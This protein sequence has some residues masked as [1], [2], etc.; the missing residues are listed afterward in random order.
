[1]FIVN[2]A[3]GRGRC[4]HRWRAFLPQLAGA[5]FAF[6]VHATTRPGEASEVARQAQRAGF[7]RIVA[8]GGDGTLHEVVNGVAVGQGVVGVLPFGTGN[9]VARSLGLPRRADA[10]FEMLADNRTVSLD[11]ALVNGRRCLMA[12]GVG[13]DGDVVARIRQHPGIQRLGKFGYA[14]GAC[15]ALFAFRPQPAR[16]TVDDTSLFVPRAWMITIANCPYYAGG[17][18]I[19]PDARWHDGLLDVCVVADLD[20]GRF[21]RLFPLVFSGRHVRHHPYVTVLRGQR[22]CVQAAAAWPGHT[23]GESLVADGLRAEVMQGGVRLLAAVPDLVPRATK[24]RADEERADEER[25]DEK[26]ADK[27]MQGGGVP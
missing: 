11:L 25:I 3:A 18:R 6:E 22:V 8:V 13:F 5:R 1:M 16:I 20:V 17:M 23:D 7:E 24:A 9:D 26:R 12:A 10:L 15:A 14:A 19:C 21:V 27:Q 2:P 4:G